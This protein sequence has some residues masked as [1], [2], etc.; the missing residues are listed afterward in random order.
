MGT[1]P[2][3]SWAAT[4]GGSWRRREIGRSSRSETGGGG[5][6]LVTPAGGALV[7]GAPPGGALR[8]PLTRPHREHPGRVSSAGVAAPRR[9]PD[10][11]ERP[12]PAGGGVARDPRGSP[13]ERVALGDHPRPGRGG[14][15]G[16]GPV[17]AGYP[18]A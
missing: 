10:R 17:P 7:A 3:R 14:G 11:T 15:G 13:A 1:S 6:G 2:S 12:R 5:G 8:D 4:C 16:G 18:P 9:G